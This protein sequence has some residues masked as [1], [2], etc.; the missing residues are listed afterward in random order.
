MALTGDGTP[1]AAWQAWLRSRR[2]PVLDPRALGRDPTQGMV[3]VAPHPDD[4]TLGVGGLMALARAAG[5][6]IT[7]VAVT[8]GDA[9]HPLS[10]TL[11]PDELARLRIAEQRAALAELGLADVEI[12]RLDIPDGR[13]RDQ[14]DTVVDRLAALLP[15]GS[16][17]LATFAADGHPDHDAVGAAAARACR[18]RGIPLL[19]FPIWTWHW[20]RPGDDRVPWHRLARVPLP[21]AL[22]EAKRRA[23]ACFRTQVRPLSEQ[24]GDEAILTPAMLARLLRDEETVLLPADGRFGSSSQAEARH[25]AASHAEVGA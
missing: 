25:L 6:H 12:R 19:E 9:S 24:P 23:V 1:E 20:A 13:V 3:V 5:A 7:V 2:W 18:D 11:R 15:V 22:V 17:C 8:N 21:P 16:T 10:P 4:E 14:F